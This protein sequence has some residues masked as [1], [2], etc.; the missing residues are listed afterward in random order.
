M[1]TSD[2]EQ[3]AV[4]S[5]PEPKSGRYFRKH[6]DFFTKK[7]GDI[8]LQADDEKRVC[9]CFNL[10][11]LQ[12]ASS[13]FR[14][15]PASSHPTDMVDGLPRY[16]ILES[17]SDG[18]H[19]FLLAVR[20]LSQVA[21]FV[22]PEHII[23]STP[24]AIYE[25][26]QIGARLDVPCIYRLLDEAL[27]GASHIF[28]TP[29]ILFAI[30]ELSAISSKTMSA[31]RSTLD[32]DITAVDKYLVRAVHVQSPACWLE[33]QDLHLRRAQ[34]MARVR[35]IC[36][37]IV[38]G[39]CRDCGRDG[40]AVTEEARLRIIQG[41]VDG[42]EEV[43]AKMRRVSFVSVCGACQG[44][45]R[46]HIDSLHDWYMRFISEYRFLAPYESPKGGW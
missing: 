37:E 24:A 11:Q 42:P 22:L 28:H 41:A 9:F 38:M 2:S 30:W 19:V 31:S 17:S 46:K 33:L 43:A 36:E 35:S 15:L 25:A 6:A 16:P 5:Q 8:M 27:S 32:L 3:Q 10:V 40:R 18:L 26:A 45:T 12:A 34:G 14:D 13:F 21:P 39:A 44:R 20:S 29:F 4:S 1:S 7:S 23:Q